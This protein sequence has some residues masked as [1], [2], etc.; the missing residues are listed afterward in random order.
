M[1]FGERLEKKTDIQEIK[2]E[3][4]AIYIFFGG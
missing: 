4:D 2:R 1:K 3:Y